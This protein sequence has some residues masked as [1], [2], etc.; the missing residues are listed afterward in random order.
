MG[1]VQDFLKRENTFAVVGVSRNPEKYGH[2]VFMYLK[3]AG[4]KVYPVNPNIDNIDDSIRCYS[5]LKELPVRPDVVITVVPPEVTEAIVNEAAELGIDRI[6]MQPGSESEKAAE[7]CRDKNI[8][9]VQGTCIM[10]I[11]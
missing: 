11:R 6:W 9:F 3:N 7:Y 4:Y 2:R 8:R 10:T 5:S 1:Q